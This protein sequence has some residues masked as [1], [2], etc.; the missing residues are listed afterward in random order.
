MAFL[1]LVICLLSFQ[2]SFSFPSSSSSSFADF[3]RRFHLPRFGIHGASKHSY[4][5]HQ[6]SSASPPPP[7]TY[8]TR[9]FNATLDHF[10][11]ANAQTFPLRYLINEDEFAGSGSPIF[12]Y[13]GNEGD[14]AWFAENTGFVWEIAPEFGATVVFAEH[15]YYGLSLP[16]GNESYA[17]PKRLG[18]LTSEQALADFVDVIAHL[19]SGNDSKYSASPVIAFGG[20]YGGMLAAWLRMKYP[21]MVAG[22]LAAS[23]PIWQFTGLAPCDSY[24]KGVTKD[25][26]LADSTGKCVGAIKRSWEEIELI[27]KRSG[28]LSWLSLTFRLCQP[29]S[30]TDELKDWLG[31]TWGDVAMVDYPY[32]ANFLEPLP[33]WPIRHICQHLSNDWTGEKLMFSLR[34]AVLVY[35]NST[36]QSKCLNTSVT[37]GAGL[38]A[39]G[40][41]FQACTEMVMPFC[42]TG[43]DDFFPPAKWD[44]EAF[45]QGCRQVWGIEPR[46]LW[47]EKEYWGKNISAASN[48][49]FS[50][51][52]LDPWAGGGVLTAPHERVVVLKIKEGAHH[53]DLRFANSK[54]PISV[55]HARKSERKLIRRFIR[56]H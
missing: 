2:H 40:W 1:G 26:Q 52:D 16:F 24:N 48:I 18:F 4:E 22:A 51:G 5:S 10:N 47:V 36:G 19:K 15:R 7:P 34:D 6:N 46:P 21:N 9:W 13:T 33:E 42:S 41:W 53:L 35:Y 8:S 49:I 25:F 32:P 14:I 44:Y 43:V 23:A 45:A 30:S 29:L 55:I 27:G 11:L 38:D 28:G 39:R 20:S 54:D 50:N 12:L 37:A 3:R 56:N 17:D 31:E